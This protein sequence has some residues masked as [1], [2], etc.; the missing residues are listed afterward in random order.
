[1]SLP[2]IKVCA[3][4]FDHPRAVDL[5]DE[6]GRPMAWGHLVALWGW[7]AQYAPTGRVEAR[8]VGR[9][10]ERAAR[11]DGE[12]GAFV[13]AA[14][15]TGWLALEDGAATV[16][17]WD[18]HQRA[19]LDKAEKDRLRVAQKRASDVSRVCRATVARQSGDCLT[20]VA[21]EKEKEKERERE[22]ELSSGEPD[23]P[24]PLTPA[25]L[26]READVTTVLAH[27]RE[28]VDMP[29]AAIEGKAGEGRRKRVRARLAEGLSVAD[30]CLVAD[31]AARDDW[32]MGRDPKA[33]P[34][35]WRDVETVYRDRAQCE[36]LTLLA[37]SPATGPPRGERGRAAEAFLDEWEAA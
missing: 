24:P 1:M 26:E 28:R 15:A 6:L 29:R 10:V 12:P 14:V 7:C 13:A 19:H 11:W 18:D 30:L 34:G 23:A 20:T 37:K 25:K 4:L 21:G 5:G 16:C 33:R 35:G 32:L 3:D 27:W 17:G 8:N 22:E 9:T 36:R 31:G 2:W